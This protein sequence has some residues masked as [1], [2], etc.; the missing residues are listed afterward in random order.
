MMAQAAV[1]LSQ[2]PPTTLCSRV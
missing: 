1:N 2:N